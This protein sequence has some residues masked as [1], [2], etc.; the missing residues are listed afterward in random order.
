MR[1]VDRWSGFLE[2]EADAEIALPDFAGQ[3]VLVTGGGG[4]IGSAL[5]RHL[6]ASGVERCTLIDNAEEGLARFEEESRPEDLRRLHLVLGDVAHVPMLRQT[7]QRDRPEVVIHAAARKYVPL[8]QE[9]ALAAAATNVLGTAA[10]LEASREAGVKSF[11]LLST[12]K[13]VLPVSVMGATKYLAEQMVLSEQPH[14][15]M[16]AQ[17]LRLC[18]VLGSTGSVAPRFAGQID[19]GEALTVT[20]A[21]ATRY[22][23]SLPRARDLVLL[24]AGSTLPTGLAVPQAGPPRSVLALAR[25]MLSKGAAARQIVYTG[26]RA[27]ERL[28]EQMTSPEETL[29]HDGNG[30]LLHV[31]VPRMDAGDLHFAVEATRHAVEAYHEQAVVQVLSQ[32]AGTRVPDAVQV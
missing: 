3:R 28:H 19:R 24:A 2:G 27:G 6:L 1:N 8:L 29:M 18:N 10:L 30:S 16:R 23:V 26:L 11:L 22:F 5:A 31:C 25:F 13:A 20:H 14:T 7:M 17:V 15:G 21:D 4:Y 32:L 12:D 9:N